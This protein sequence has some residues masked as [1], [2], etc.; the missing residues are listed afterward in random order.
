MSADQTKTELA[1]GS[2]ET[3]A[4]EQAKKSEQITI[5]PKIFYLVAPKS[6]ENLWE[7]REKVKKLGTDIA[8]GSDEPIF[9]ARADLSYKD[10]KSDEK[11]KAELEKVIKE[12]P[13]DCDIVIG[14]HSLWVENRSESPSGL[15]IT[16]CIIREAER[17][18][19]IL[20]GMVAPNKPRILISSELSIWQNP[21]E[22]LDDERN[23]ARSYKIYQYKP[24]FSLREG[25]FPFLSIAPGVNAYK[26]QVSFNL[27]V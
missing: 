14:G 10:F 27:S 17:I 25:M 18:D 24:E 21:I 12:N 22:G 11:L 13:D 5:K 16:G 3:G 7:L 26:A 20:S 19:H 9:M 23:K 1:P 15:A 6:V 2:E 4:I 8:L